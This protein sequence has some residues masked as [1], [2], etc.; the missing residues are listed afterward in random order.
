MFTTLQWRKVLLSKLIVRNNE[1][2]DLVLK[3]PLDDG[4]INSS[5]TCEEIF[6]EISNVIRL[7]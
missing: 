2:H 6:Q 3:T 1:P 5:A 7:Q 4:V